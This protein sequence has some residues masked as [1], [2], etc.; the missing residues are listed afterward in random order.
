[1]SSEVVNKEFSKIHSLVNLFKDVMMLN[2]KVY[3]W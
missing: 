3:V 2:D 1:M